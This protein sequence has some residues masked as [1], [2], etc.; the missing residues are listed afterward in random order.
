M[1]VLINWLHFFQEALWKTICFLLHLEMPVCSK[2]SKL[3]GMLACALYFLFFVSFL[4]ACK[5]HKCIHGAAVIRILLTFSHFLNL[6]A[7]DGW[8]QLQ[9]WF[10]SLNLLRQLWSSLFIAYLWLSRP[11]VDQWSFVYQAIWLTNVKDVSQACMDLFYLYNACRTCRLCIFSSLARRLKTATRGIW[12][13]RL[14]KKLFPGLVEERV[15]N[16]SY[17]HSPHPC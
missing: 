17:C 9:P 8:P 12:N 7:K 15:E 2:V 11:P 13:L 5:I 6:T 10:I 14:K 4:A 3:A 1:G 16:W